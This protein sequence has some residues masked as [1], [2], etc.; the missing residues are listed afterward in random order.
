MSN[1]KYPEIGQELDKY[2]YENILKDELMVVPET[3]DKREGSVIWD[4]LAPGAYKTSEYYTVLKEA[5]RQTYAQTSTGEYLELRVGE[6]GIYRYPATKAEKLGTFTTSSD[7]PVIIPIGSMFTTISE[8]GGIDYIAVREHVDAEGVIIPGEYI[9]EC[10]EL[11]EIGN[12]YQGP[13][14]SVS[15]INGLASADMTTLIST[16]EEIETDEALYARYEY[17]INN[18]TFGGNRSDYITYVNS[19]EGV[20]ATQVYP[21]WNGGGTVK[22]SVVDD[23]FNP[24]SP[25]KIAEIQVLVDPVNA[26]GEQGTGLGTAPLGHWV[27]TVTPENVIIDVVTTVLLES[28]TT[29]EQVQADVEKAITSYLSDIKSKW[30]KSDDFG[31]YYSKVFVSQINARILTVPKIINVTDTTI[32]GSTSDLT[33]T[34][35][36]TTQQ[37]CNFGSVVLNV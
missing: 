30:A 14:L 7:D 6:R 18:P 34:Q 33:L 31:N 26:E 11:G 20:G 19:I 9:L 23:E 32:N 3:Q 4:A 28:G 8:T 21:I 35:S 37:I 1:N 13:L 5:N 15:Y 36:G 16:G 22:L 12:A 2:T 25:E 29:V 10:V 17:K 27:T 24:L